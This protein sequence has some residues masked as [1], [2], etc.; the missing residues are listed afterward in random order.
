MALILQVDDIQYQADNAKK[1]PCAPVYEPWPLFNLNATVVE[2]FA[3]YLRSRDFAHSGVISRNPPFFLFTLSP[4]PWTSLESK[5][6]PGRMLTIN[7]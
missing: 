2:A 4:I 6:A 3:S 7:A 1:S 5:Q